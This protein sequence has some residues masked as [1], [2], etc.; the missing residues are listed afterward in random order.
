M[1]A[2]A[3]EPPPA[4]VS[5][6][7]RAANDE[8]N[9]CIDARRFVDA[10]PLAE[11][12]AALAP[13]WA[14]PW[15]NLVVGYKHA[16]RWQDCL[17]ACDRRLALDTEHADGVHW[18]AGI[19]ATALGDWQLARR[20]WEA[21]GLDVPDGDGPIAMKLGATPIRVGAGAA[22]EVVWCDRIDP[23]RARIEGVPLPD[24]GRRCGDLIL[25][26]GEPRGRRRLGERSVA[27]FDE[28]AV[29]AP[30]RLLTWEVVVTAGDAAERDAIVARLEEWDRS[31]RVEDW[32]ESVLCAPCRLGE[33]HDHGDDD[34]DG[35]EPPP[36]QVE[37]RLGL[38]AQDD[39]ALGPLRRLG[40]WWRREVRSV[41][42]T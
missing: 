15:S 37:R 26:D 2:G 42:R 35:G 25:H 4:A 12:A 20:C 7:A 1:S 28:L 21:I 11:R 30:S 9:D 31:V 40:M 5:D 41:K 14:D 24:S 33:P 36:W 32:T 19:A 22:R 6:E 10:I 39:S 29:L 3:G 27:V 13:D 38:A 17:D 34:D 8:A 23:C 18:N 16:R